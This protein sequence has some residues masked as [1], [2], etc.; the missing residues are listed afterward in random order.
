MLLKVNIFLR[1]LTIHPQII[2]I[3]KIDP[4]ILEIMVTSIMAVATVVEAMI[5]IA[6]VATV[7]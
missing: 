7:G 4:I 1:I 6:A 2:S 3:H 5:L